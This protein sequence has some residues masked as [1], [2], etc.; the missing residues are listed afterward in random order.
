MTETSGLLLAMAE[1][2][3]AENASIGHSE[4][5]G[6]MLILLGNGFHLLPKPCNRFLQTGFQG[7]QLQMGKQLF[8]FFGSQ[9]LRPGAHI[10]RGVELNGVERKTTWAQMSWAK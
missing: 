7:S 8:Q 1:P 4:K 6:L 10:A 3:W 2:V 9:T 5:P